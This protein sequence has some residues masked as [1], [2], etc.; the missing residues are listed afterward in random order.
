MLSTTV[1][2][3]YG[4]QTSWCT[5][6]SLSIYNSRNQIRSLDWHSN[7]CMLQNLQQQKLDT[8]FRLST[9]K[10]SLKIYNSRNQIRSL[11]S[12]N[13]RK[14]NSYLQQQKLD[15]EFRPIKFSNTTVR[16]YNSRNQIRSLDY[17]LASNLFAT[18]TTVEIRYGVQTKR[19]ADGRI[20]STT[21][22]I[23]YG[24]Q[25][26]CF[27]DTRPSSTTVEIRYGVQTCR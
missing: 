26:K 5:L 15:T 27:I 7:I 11:D 14:C 21:V 12:C 22:E 2:I 10:W 24:V 8:E 19:R 4:V 9:S 23:R 3:R 13:R 6:P 16:I 25:T 18:S 20:Q 17:N 1:E